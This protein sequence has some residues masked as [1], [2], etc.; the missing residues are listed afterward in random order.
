MHL[1]WNEIATSEMISP[2]CEKVSRYY[3]AQV[4]RKSPLFYAI[5]E[6]NWILM[7]FAQA[8]KVKSNMSFLTA[9]KFSQQVHSI[10][11]WLE[12]LD[13]GWEWSRNVPLNGEN[14]LWS[15]SVSNWVKSGAHLAEKNVLMDHFSHVHAEWVNWLSVYLFVCL[16]L[17]TLWQ[18][19][20][21]SRIWI[22]I[23]MQFNK[24]LFYLTMKRKVNPLAISH[25][26]EL[27]WFFLDQNIFKHTEC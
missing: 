20:L 7:F 24:M 19:S 14:L 8:S 6:E 4:F 23:H 18:N 25:G 17:S 26:I 12:S 5:M 22:F 10:W 11:S 13:V 16:S 3:S 27:I 21:K 1:L 2:H 9:C 15:F